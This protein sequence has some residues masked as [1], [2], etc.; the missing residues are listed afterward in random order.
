MNSKQ[1]LNLV[2][3]TADPAF[4]VDATGSITA[5]NKAATELFG[6]DA[7][8]AIGRRCHEVLHGS[9]ETGVVC[10]AR[11]GIQRAIVDNRPV[12]NV[13]IQFETRTG[14]KWCNVSV[15]IDN[16]YYHESRC[17]IH[18]ARPQELHKRLERA[19]TEFV[20]AQRQM[21][22]DGVATSSAR[23]AAVSETLT[24]RE[25]AIL[26]RLAM[27]QSTNSIANELSISPATVRNHIKNVLRKL[28]AH[29]RLEAIRYAESAGLL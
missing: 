9:D 17:A 25:I 18:I 21:G 11:C 16:G 2:D 4:A 20:L 19:A 6:L 24:P 26:N 28:G 15:L 10:P 7:S 22:H 3:G 13:D 27:G 12:G 14:K 23:W 8:E 1:I 29:T 5:W